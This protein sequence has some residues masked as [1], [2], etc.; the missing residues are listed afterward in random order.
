MNTVVIICICIL[1]FGIASI[2]CVIT[3]YLDKLKKE[4][5]KTNQYCKDLR[6]GKISPLDKRH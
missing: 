6:N 1:I 4:R 5:E 3:D 2:P